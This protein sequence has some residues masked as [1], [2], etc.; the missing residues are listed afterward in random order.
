MISGLYVFC[1][2]L[3]SSS[4]ANIRSRISGPFSTFSKEDLTS[5]QESIFTS[6]SKPYAV[7]RLVEER[8]IPLCFPRAFALMN[9]YYLEIPNLV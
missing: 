8:S 7:R 3:R 5:A 4:R 9:C 6:S 2:C 1:L